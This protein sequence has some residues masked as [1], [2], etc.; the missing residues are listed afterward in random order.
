MQGL[1]E[2]SRTCS[3]AKVQNVGLLAT[4]QTIAWIPDASISFNELRPYVKDAAGLV[5]GSV[6]RTVLLTDYMACDAALCKL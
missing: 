4:A 6:K 2:A 1:G 3:S 5:G